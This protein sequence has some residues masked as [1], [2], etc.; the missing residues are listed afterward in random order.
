[1]KVVAFGGGHGLFA[2]LRALRGLDV[3]ITAVVTVAD[4]GGSS[5]RLRSELGGVPP[6]DL[7]QALVALSDDGED[8]TARLFQHRFRSGGDLTE[9]A[10]G[11]LVLA[12]LF[13]LLGDPIAAL[14]HAGR[15]LKAHGRVLPMSI[16]PLQI[17]AEVDAGNGVHVVRGQADVAT[18]RGRVLRVRLLPENPPVCAEVLRAVDEADWLIFGPGSW[19][20]SVIPHLLVP[21]LRDAIAV[22]EARRLLIMNLAAD[23]ETVGLSSA[24]HLTALTTHDEKFRTNIVLSDPSSIGDH[25]KLRNAAESLGGELIVAPVARGDGTARHD[26][27][28]LAQALRAVMYKR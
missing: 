19:F 27:V 14:D 4:D 12:G 21:V 16:D 17:E 26:S 5:G 2:S 11:N 24:E 8:L 28:A 7:R 15:L 13:D 10:V 6:G 1:M 3:D 9:H 18:A 25:V 23:A 22:S 20:T